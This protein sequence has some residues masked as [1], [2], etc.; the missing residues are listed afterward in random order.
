MAILGGSK[1][2]AR[3]QFQAIPPTL[4]TTVQKLCPAS[5]FLPEGTKVDISP[6]R[7]IRSHSHGHSPPTPPL[8]RLH[9]QTLAFSVPIKL[10]KEGDI[11]GKFFPTFTILPQINKKK[12]EFFFTI[13]MS[14]QA[15]KS[16][17]L[18]W[19]PWSLVP[20]LP[21]ALTSACLLLWLH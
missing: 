13:S 15:R 11:L 9:R 8:P 17:T 5:L 14:M 21:N 12:A 16:P 7:S 20:I 10:Q 2:L 1:Y 6:F 18:S 4:C 19:G 3:F